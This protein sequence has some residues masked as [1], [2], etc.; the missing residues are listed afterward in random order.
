[1]ASCNLKLLANAIPKFDAVL[2]IFQ[3][4][5]R[6]LLLNLFHPF[7]YPKRVGVPK[8]APSDTP[9]APVNIVGDLPRLLHLIPLASISVALA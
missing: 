6:D 5:L 4:S 2:L 7:N 9:A 3:I 1:M 8:V